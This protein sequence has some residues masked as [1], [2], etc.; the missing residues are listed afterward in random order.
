MASIN[1]TFGN[2]NLTG[3]SETD[4]IFGDLGDDILD[5][6]GGADEFVFN[7]V[8]NVF[9]FDS[10]V[11]VYS[12][13]GFDIIKNFFKNGISNNSVISIDPVNHNYNHVNINAN[14]F[15]G[16]RPG[17]GVPNQI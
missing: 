1:G 2:D 6:F 9:I 13:D 7:N 3:T 15:T 14:V 17:F 8:I 16:D 4:S 5:V 11:Y 12:T 10:S